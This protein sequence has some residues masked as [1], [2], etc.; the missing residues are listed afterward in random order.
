MKT[1]VIRS[2]S[3]A[4][5][6]A[7]LTATLSGCSGSKEE[8]SMTSQPVT[9]AATEESAA[10]PAASVAE[11]TSEAEP[12]AEALA[13]V[14]Y[15][16]EYSSEELHCTY[17]DKDIFGTLYTPDNGRA[18]HPAVILS[19]G[20]NCIGADMQ[21]MAKKLAQNGIIAY[22]FDYCGGS[23]RSASSGES[24]DMS[25][26]TEQ[27]DLRHVIDMVSGLENV[28]ASQLYLYGESQG[29][30]VAAL[31]GAQMPDRIAGM[32]LIY[33]A[34]CIVDQ[35]LAM[36]P[37]TMTEPFN[38]MGGMTLSK[39]FYD[40]VPRYD[41][42]EHIK[43]FTNPVLIYQGDKDQVVNISYAHKIDEAFPDSSLTIVEGGGH[44]FGGAD[45]RLVLDGVTGFFAERGINQ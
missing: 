42:Y 40:G 2:L 35:W 21:D 9:S 37:A 25:I 31:T 4:A 33:P 39:T 41:I 27:D 15:P 7:V 18:K 22:T 13:P 44:G 43:A 3:L 28:D 19:H 32:F 26:E 6:A 16:C 11:P 14:E 24:V 20:Y 8:S 17:G 29:G 30:F 36:D 5:A 23:T 1:S 12:T 10:E 34:F 38:F 45:R